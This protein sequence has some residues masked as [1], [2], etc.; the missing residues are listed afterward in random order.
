MH[1]GKVV[2]AGAGPGDPE[3][4]TLK[5]AA[6]LH[7]ADVVLTDRLVSE[8]IL[9]R[10]VNP[11][12]QVIFVGKEGRKDGSTLQE[13][14]NRL[15][16][17]YAIQGKLV[18]RLKGGDISVFSNILGELETLK[19]NN[20]PYELVPG[21]TAAAGAAAYSGIPLTARGH[22]NGVRFLTYYEGDVHDDAYWYEL[23]GTDHTLVF[24]MS[25]ETPDALAGHLLRHGI[26]EN[27][28]IAVI[29]QATTPCQRVFT[30]T[31]KELKN[32]KVQH[33]FV[34]PRLLIIGSVVRLHET[35]GWLPD[36][37]ETKSYFPHVADKI[38]VQKIIAS[39]T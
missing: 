33:G 26:D 1:T 12:A 24:Y 25:G 17:Y 19:A 27:K 39:L 15:L 3:L 7:K 37:P 23:A 10:Y 36:S 14:I 9:Q 30:A 2:I 8:R 31:F 16:V 29:E 28:A 21:I 5:A 38:S 18:V 11:I 22:A 35:F 34:S 20:I 6:Y 4:L 13:K 32:G